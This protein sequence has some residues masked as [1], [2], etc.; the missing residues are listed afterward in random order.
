MV[1][2]IQV[3]VY[4]NDKEKKMKKLMVLVAALALVAGSAMTAAAADWNFYGS[5]RVSTFITD[6]DVA[7]TTNYEQGLQG[8]SR[9]GASVK[10][11]DELTGGFEYG[12]KV[13]LRK[14]YGEW[15]FGAGSLLVGQ[16]YTPLNYFYSNQVYGPDND[17]LAQGGVYSGR[18]GMIRL[19]FGGFEIAALA[20]KTSTL[21]SGDGTEVEVSLPGIEA[22][23]NMVMDA[24]S[25]NLGAS[26]QTYELLGTATGDHDVDSYVVAFGAKTGFGPV[27]I[28][29]NVYLGENIGNIMPLSVDGDNAWD[30][31]FADWNGTEVLD[32]EAM[33][34]ILVAS[35]KANDMFAFEAGYGYAEVETL[36]G[37][38]DDNEVQSYYVQSTITL[39]P[40]VF[41]TPEI[42]MFD[43]EEDGSEETLY[44]G[45]KWQINF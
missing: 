14:L 43:G 25:F 29:G 13:N 24:F 6:L 22:N 44:Y 15:T 37:A 41:I 26:Y 7:D 45:A 39:A 21:N 9:I 36:G 4:I 11:S 34:F 20:P 30:D 19:K 23:Y 42:G 33:G 18:Q 38:G 16:T 8:N 40:G 35:M 28:G 2:L 17:L 31:G 10:V 32:N 12:T 3:V 1:L 5:A 27:S